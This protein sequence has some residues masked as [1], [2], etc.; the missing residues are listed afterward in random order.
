VFA[1]FART[2]L[3][4]LGL[5]DSLAFVFILFQKMSK[6]WPKPGAGKHAADNDSD[7]AHYCHYDPLAVRTVRVEETTQ[8]KQWKA[9]QKTV[10]RKQ[11]TKARCLNILTGIAAGV[12]FAYGVVNYRVLKAMQDANQISRQAFIVSQ[13]SYV[14]TG[15]KDGVIAEVV[16]PKD[17]KQDAELV[18]YFQNSGHATAKLAWG[19]AAGFIAGLPPTSQDSGVKYTHP[20]KD[21]KRTRDKKTG[22]EG[23]EGESNAVP[24]DSI[25]VARLG[26]I[27]PSKLAEFRS[28]KVDL[29]VIGFYHFCD[30]LGTDRNRSFWLGFQNAANPSLEFY[31]ISD[32]DFPWFKKY[33]STAQT[34]Y[35]PACRTT[36]DK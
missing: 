14:S 6:K 1:W 35:F 25:F 31:L 21:M 29:A 3:S 16:S 23:E 13:R 7:P 4:P 33:P 36:L 30:E 9:V 19:T 5:L 32:I 34:E 17:P 24:A 18:M 12:G 15:R 26:E 28:K 20:F 10:W 11:L 22:S 8:D 27:S 2:S